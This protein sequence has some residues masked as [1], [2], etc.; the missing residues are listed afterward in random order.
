MSTL[1]AQIPVIETER[2]R[3]RAPKLAD[4]EALTA[5]FASP[6]SEMV[7]GPLSALEAHRKLLTP[8]GAWSLRGHGMWHVANKDT[9]AYLGTTGV[10]FGPGWHEEELGWSVTEEAEGK[11]IAFEAAHAARGYAACNLSL[12]GMIS[13]IDPAN[14]RSAALARRL[15]ATLE[16]EDIFLDKPV[17]VYRHPKED[18]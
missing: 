2:L 12:N 3:L 9:D 7:G 13:Y 18:L 15:G 1:I 4:L 6:R 10:S 17:H 8:F 5:F 11:G 14:T 16:R